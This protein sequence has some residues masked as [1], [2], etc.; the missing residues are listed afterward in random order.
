[1]AIRDISYT[2]PFKLL[3][4][5]LT[6]QEYDTCFMYSE[7]PEALKKL[8]SEIVVSVKVVGK[9]L[10]FADDKEERLT[11]QIYIIREKAEISFRFGLS[12]NDTEAF[13]GA[14]GKPSEIAKKRQEVKNKL[15]YSLLSCIGSDYYIPDTFEEFCDEFGYDTDSRKAEKIFKGALEQ[16]KMLH[17]I[18]K[19]EEIDCLPR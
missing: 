10:Y 9:T 7:N 16:S 12:L 15:L 19:E 11:L 13:F 5:R 3:S 8:L 17:T 1:M 2:G 18:F 14:P 6:L 4:G